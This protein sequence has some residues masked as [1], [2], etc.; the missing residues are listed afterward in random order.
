M[1]RAR[2][3][4]GPVARALP[5][6]GL[7]LGPSAWAAMTTITP[8]ESLDAAVA[9]AQAGDTFLLVTGTYSACITATV[10]VTIIGRGSGQTTID[11]QGGAPHAITA[12]AP[13]TLA[14]FTLDNSGGSGTKAGITVTG[15]SLTAQDVVMS[16]LKGQ[17]TDA[18]GISA[19]TSTVTLYG[20]DIARTTGTSGGALYAEQSSVTIHGGSFT[21][22]NATNGGAI[23]L[24]SSP[25]DV[26]ATSFD[27]NKASSSGGAIY[28]DDAFGVSPYISLTGTTLSN[29]SAQAG[30]GGGVYS[31]VAAVQINATNA[32]FD[33]ND[34]TGEGGAIAGPTALVVRGGLF[35][36]NI[37]TTNGGAIANSNSTVLTGSR[38]SGNAVLAGGGGALAAISPS[39]VEL[40]GCTFDA[41][42]SP[43]DGGAVYV[44]DYSLSSTNN[45]YTSN[46][47]SAGSGGAVYVGGS[48]AGYD[49]WSTYGDPV[50]GTLKNS[51]KFGGALGTAGTM[52]MDVYGSS[53]YKNNAVNDGGGVYTDTGSTT[54]FHG[55]SFKQNHAGVDGGAWFVAD[56]GQGGAFETQ[57]VSNSATSDG[58]AVAVQQAGPSG[59]GIQVHGTLFSGNTSVGAGAIT[60]T[61]GTLNVQDSW[62]DTNQGDR[63]G[64]IYAKHTDGLYLYGDLLCANA[65]FNGAG[66]GLTIDAPNGVRDIFNSVFVKNTAWT[67]GGAAYETG[68]LTADVSYWYGNDFIANTSDSTFYDGHFADNDA[69]AAIYDSIFLSNGDY[70]LGTVNLYPPTHDYYGSLFWDQTSGVFYNDNDYTVAGY[71]NYLENPRIPATNAGWSDDGNCYDDRFIHNETTHIGWLGAGVGVQATGQYKDMTLDNDGDGQTVLQGDCDDNDGA[72]H[73]GGIDAAG[74]SVDEDCVGY[75]NADNDLDGYTAGVDCDDS[76]AGVHPGAVESWYDGVDQDCS[77][78]DDFDQDGDGVDSNGGD[79][80]DSDETIHTGAIEVWYDTVDQ[81][82]DGNDND[83]DRDGESVTS[84]CDDTEP[85]AFHGNTNDVWY[86][87]I[88]GDCGGN[89]DYDQDGDGDDVTPRGQ[90]CDDTDPTVSSSHVEVW[91]NGVD[92]AC[93]GGDDYDQDLDGYEGGDLTQPDCDDTDPA[94]NPGVT[95]D[96]P[97]DGVDSDCDGTVEIPPDD[98]LDGVANDLELAN[99]TD[100]GNPDSDSDGLSDGIE[101]GPDLEGAPRDSDGDST[102]DALDTDDDDDGVLTFVESSDADGDGVHDEMNSDGDAFPDQIDPDDDGD[103]IATVDE[104]GAGDD[105][106]GDGI[107]NY[108][109]LDSDDDLSADAAEGTADADGDGLPDFLDDGLDTD[110][111][112]GT[113]TPLDK[114]GFGLGCDVSGS[115]G[116]GLLGLGLLAALIGRRRR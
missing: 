90:D 69:Y 85:L 34:A 23:F 108:L 103:T 2:S 92:N 87:G 8:S 70:A 14:G 107:P 35:N 82:C 77:F 9:A 84:D 58:G 22:N 99:Q 63:F 109:D 97:E 75:Y 104:G 4:R 32:V 110:A 96:D 26:R 78:D 29:N 16:D 86:D 67:F 51:A 64:A 62:F 6:V 73:R 60:Q 115:R 52:S 10:E 83:A 94:V 116:P 44:T 55:A 11:C 68:R 98:D 48:G 49:I 114:F 18:G 45:H 56:Q 17:G 88:D 54:W 13:I 27:S 24:Q 57:F 20:V 80:D 43:T 25:L 65:S 95:F 7:F 3:I 72:R 71:E 1:V 61:Y 42:N 113:P 37:A 53:F 66:G 91:Y 19:Y 100:P 106:D 79:C 28:V 112:R 21:S 41:N 15:A 89:D 36:A 59:Y 40:D 33:T 93:D 105:F 12:T 47:A 31:A 50:D 39:Y 76:D 30:S 102:I 46:S 81:D 111:T 38:L 101:W 74:D 5:L